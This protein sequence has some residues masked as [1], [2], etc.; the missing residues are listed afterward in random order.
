MPPVTVPPLYPR[1]E[2]PVRP[3]VLSDDLALD[4]SDADDAAQDSPP[5][6]ASD[7]GDVAKNSKLFRSF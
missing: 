4:P 2:F 6:E 1:R 7:S 5:P 3:I